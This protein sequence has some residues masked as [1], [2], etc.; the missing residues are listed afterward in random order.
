VPK[1]LKIFDGSAQA[2]LSGAIR[3]ASPNQYE[4]E[5]M[6]NQAKA[7]LP[8]LPPPL[9][10]PSLPAHAP[11]LAHDCLPNALYLSQ[12]IPHIILK[13][14]EYGCVYVGPSQDL[15]KIAMH[16][17]PESLDLSTVKSVTGAGDR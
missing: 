4:L 2:L 12:Y 5:A 3:Y 10:S 17:A 1:S 6:V 8:L 9:V 11:G 14:G 13:L 16:F 15:E 7:Q